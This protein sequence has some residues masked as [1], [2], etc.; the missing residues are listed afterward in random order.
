VAVKVINLPM[1]PHESANARA[2]Q[3]LKEQLH[4]IVQDFKTEV[5]VCCDLNHPNLVRLLGYATVP[6]LLLVR[7]NLV[8]GAATVSD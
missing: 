8:V 3:E 1:E 4:Q 2:K 7:Q 5:E 6:R